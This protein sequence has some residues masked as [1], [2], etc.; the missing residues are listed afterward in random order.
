M[1]IDSNNKFNDL[2]KRCQVSEYNLDLDLVNE[3]GNSWNNSINN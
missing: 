1:E 2:W 3:Q